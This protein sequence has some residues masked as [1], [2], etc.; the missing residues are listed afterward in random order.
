MH[1]LVVG[2]LIPY[3]MYDF[4]V[5]ACNSIGCVNSTASSGRTLPAGRSPRAGL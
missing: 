4:L 3:A 5:G 1:S 2:G